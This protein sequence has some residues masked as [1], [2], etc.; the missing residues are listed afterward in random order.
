M[1]VPGNHLPLG[2]APNDIL[3][4]VAEPWKACEVHSK[5]LAGAGNVLLKVC[6]YLFNLPLDDPF[7][8][9]LWASVGADP[10]LDQLM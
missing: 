1:R 6:C 10:C 9:T 8:V 4:F 7:L 5:T 3:S 2:K